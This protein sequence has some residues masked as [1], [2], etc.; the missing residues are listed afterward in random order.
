MC[1]R[2]CEHT[3]WQGAVCRK[4]GC[5]H[6]PGLLHPPRLSPLPSPTVSPSLPLTLTLSADPAPAVSVQVHRQCGVKG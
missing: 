2:K 4:R 1:I 3:A 5:C 6:H